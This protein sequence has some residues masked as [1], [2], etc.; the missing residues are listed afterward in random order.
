MSWKDWEALTGNVP[1]FEGLSSAG[2]AMISAQNMRPPEVSVHIL[3]TFYCKSTWIIWR[4]CLLFLF[5]YHYAKVST[6]I[7]NIKDQRW[8]PW[9]KSRNKRESCW[10]CGRTQRPQTLLPLLSILCFQ[11]VML[12]C[13]KMHTIDLLIE[14]LQSRKREN[15]FF[16][17]KAKAKDTD[18]KIGSLQG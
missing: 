6:K 18:A 11:M 4:S 5:I 10:W 15:D 17:N 9:R 2:S 1:F 12:Y 8:T 3:L 14:I 7:L 13:V 16:P